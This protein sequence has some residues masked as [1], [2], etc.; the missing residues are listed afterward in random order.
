M[1]KL[2][3]IIP[4]LLFVSIC[5]SQDE[6]TPKNDTT[7][8]KMGNSTIIIVKNHPDDEIDYDFTSQDSTHQKKSCQ[9]DNVGFHVDLGMNGYL[10]ADK[11]FSLP[12]TQEM[13]EL[14]YARSRTF[15][16]N[17]TLKKADIIKD[18][19]YFSPGLGI[20]WN[21]YFFKNNISIST[22][23]DVT[24][25]SEDS[26]IAY[27]KYKLRA[28]YLQVPLLLGARF[29]DLKKPIGVQIGV[30]GGL[31]IRSIIKRKFTLEDAQ[32]KDKIRSDFNLHPFKFEAVARIIVGSIGLYSKYSL[33]SLFDKNTPLEVYPFSFGVSLGE[34]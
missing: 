1:K 28:T 8:I 14:D 22:T 27:D 17:L 32:H 13:M 18:R 25:F 31:R 29:G 12:S 33:T 16:F 3:L 21:N 23:G 30:I 15:A 2:A 26:T 9:D 4:L 11:K 5:F 6:E 20:S 19:L 24:T 10:S 34:F 7:K